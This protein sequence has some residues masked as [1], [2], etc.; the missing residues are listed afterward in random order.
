MRVIVTGSRDWPD[1]GGRH[2]RQRALGG[3]GNAYCP[4]AGFTRNQ[5]MADLGADRVLAF[6]KGDSSGT[7]DMIKRAEEAGI[8]VDLTEMP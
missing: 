2:R 8:P 5:Q 7:R 1:A 4:L 6:C 3:V